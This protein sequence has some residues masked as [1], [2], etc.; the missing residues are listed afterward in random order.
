M[1]PKIPVGTV[2]KVVLDRSLD[3]PLFVGDT[4]LVLG[5]SR[6]GNADVKTIAAE[7][8]GM[9]W[10]VEWD[11]IEPIS[12]ADALPSMPDAKEP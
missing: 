6:G 11:A 4:V 9:C 2:C 1:E 3:A 7:W 12:Q 5:V 8:V 10:F